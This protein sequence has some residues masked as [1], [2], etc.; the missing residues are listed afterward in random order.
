MKITI[1]AVGTRGDVQPYIALGLGLQA[2]GHKV[3]IAAPSNFEEFIVGYGLIYKQLEANFRELMESETVQELMAKRNPIL[4]YKNMTKALQRILECFTADSWTACQ[5]TDGI[6][7]S[8]ASVP[9]YSIAERLGIPSCWAPLQPLSRT[10]AFPSVIYSDGKRNNETLNWISHILEEQFTWQ[11]SRKFINSWRKNVLGLEPY[12][13]GGPYKILEKKKFPIIYGYS[14]SVL[15][16]P[17]DWGDWIHVTGYWYLNHPADWKPSDSLLQFLNDGSTPIYI[18]FGS[19]NNREAEVMTRIIAEGIKKV[20][21]RAILSTGWDSLGGIELPDTILKV[22]SVP[23]DWLLPRTTCI[24]HHGGAGTTA[25]ALRAGIPGLVVPHIMDQPFWGQ[26]VFDLGVGPQPIPRKQ[27]TAEKL[28]QGITS[29]LNNKEMKERSY[30]LGAQIRD[31][32]GITK[33]VELIEKYL[34]K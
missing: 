13:F 25:A 15:P 16:K 21:V 17:K 27:L 9:G 11:G 34:S 23:H 24:I 2:A 8:S 10:K 32:N 30:L 18:G 33:A 29:M 12:P 20:N 1:L 5:N 28:A 14:S 3:S 19:M 26:R 22:D 31:E 6:I 7:F 4:A